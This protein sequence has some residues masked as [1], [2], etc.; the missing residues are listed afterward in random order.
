[1]FVATRSPV[2][3]AAALALML[4]AMSIGAQAQSAPASRPERR[5]TLEDQQAVAV[6]IYNQDLALVKESRKLTLE[7]GNNRIALRDVN[8]IGNDALD[9]A[10]G[11]GLEVFVRVRSTRAPQPAWLRGSDGRYEVELVAGEE[12]VSPGQACVFYDAPSG[13]ARVLGGGFIQSARAKRAVSA[14]PVAEAM[15]G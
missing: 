9:R 2:A 5:S 10:V 15:R 14:A 13:Q 7:E 11:D 6:T 12:G 1:M 8:W 3:L 4:G